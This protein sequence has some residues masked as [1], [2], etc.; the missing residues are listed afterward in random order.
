M[1]GPKSR[2]RMGNCWRVALACLW[3]GGP[4]MET[5]HAG[6]GGQWRK[7]RCSCCVGNAT[8]LLGIWKSEG[9]TGLRQLLLHGLVC[10]K[11]ISHHPA[12]CWQLYL[13]VQACVLHCLRSPEVQKLLPHGCYPTTHPRQELA[14]L[15]K[16]IRLPLWG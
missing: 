4:P 11:C 16:A 12:V 8:P 1:W 3:A 10:C 13:G 2:F 6:H 7:G 5:C 14:V 9:C 15:N